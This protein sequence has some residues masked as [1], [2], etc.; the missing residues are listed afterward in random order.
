MRVVGDVVFVAVVS[1]RREDQGI[2]FAGMVN[3]RLEVGP[4]SSLAGVPSE[5][6]MTFAPMTAA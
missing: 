4:C 2:F 3:R 5:M 6:L 1:G